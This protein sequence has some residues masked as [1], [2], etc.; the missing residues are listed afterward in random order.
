MWKFISVIKKFC[1]FVKNFDTSEATHV[2]AGEPVVIKNITGD[3]IECFTFTET[4]Y[5][6]I[7]LIRIFNDEN[8]SFCWNY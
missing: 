2:V 4:S 5:Q 1:V 7:M 8:I 3:K 6:L